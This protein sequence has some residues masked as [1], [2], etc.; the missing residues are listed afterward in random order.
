MTSAIRPPLFRFSL[1]KA[2]SRLAAGVLLA[3]FFICGLV[4]FVIHRSEIQ[5]RQQASVTVENLSQVIEQYLSGLVDKTD[6]ALLS[7]ADEFARQFKA[8]GIDRASLDKFVQQRHF[9][10]P[11]LGGLRIADRQ[12]L[13]AIGTG[14]LS[15][16]PISIADRPYFTRLR[17]NADAGLVIFG[18]VISR[19]TGKWVLILA[20]RL[21]DA[22][23]GFAG[24]VY[25]IV[26]VASV[27]QALASLDLGEL[28]SITLYKYDPSHD[29]AGTI[30]ARH[31]K[32]AGPDDSVGSTAM[33]A[34]FRSLLLSG[35]ASA[36]YHARSGLDHVL[37]TF[38]YR[39]VPGHPLIV[40]V[41]MAD[42]DFLSGWRHEAIILIGLLISF[43]LLTVT[44]A[45]ALDRW[46]RRR[47]AE[48]ALAAGVFH[49]TQEGIMITDAK[50]RIVSANPAFSQIT[51]YSAEEAVGNDPRLF[52]SKRHDR[53][54]F[55]DMW[56]QLLDFGRWQG[57]IWNRRKNGEIYLSMLN[58]TAL[59]SESGEVQKFVAVFSDVTEL[60]HKDDQLKRMAYQDSL[61]GLPN[62]LLLADRLSQ[63]IELAKRSGT[64]VALLFIDLDNFKVVNDSLGHNVGDTLLGLVAERLQSSLRRS[65]TIARTGG[66][67]FVV[68]C[69]DVNDAGE[70]AEVAEKLIHR[71]AEPFWLDHTPMRIGASIGVALFPGDGE[72][73]TTLMRAADTAM[74]RAKAEGRN[75]FRFF[76]ASMMSAAV[77]RLQMESALRRA[78]SDGEFELYYQPKIDL[79]TGRALGSEA[80]IRWNRKDCGLVTPMAFIPVAEEIGLIC[81]IGD[82]VLM[83]A[84]RQLLE[85]KRL[86]LPP[87]SVAV[88]VSARQFSQKTFVDRIEALLAEHGLDPS[89]L[90][91]ELTEST[92]MAQP[93]RAVDQL[94]RLRAIGVNVAVD[95]FGTGYSSLSYLK[96]LP[97]KTIKIDRS[98]V[99]GVD[100]D[101]DN[102]AIVRAI[103]GLAESLGMSVVA[104]GVETEGEE[105]HLKAAG[106]GIAQG[107]RYAKPLPAGN[108]ALWLGGG[109]AVAQ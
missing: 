65:D 21:D 81:E 33:S 46:W 51:G 56:R 90:E 95:D 42:E 4:G 48:T 107:Y 11:N 74:Y 104:E 108:F 76:D 12:G 30:V 100:N 9:Q 24:I 1:A 2:T 88:N 50:G 34:E 59:R 69:P 20:R 5:Y 45:W 8:D 77:E 64:K 52:A 92:V 3:N 63:S 67:E 80:L 96:R 58:I 38:Y 14:D 105:A 32:G 102:R 39:W 62:R 83:E 78:L 15:N 53:A 66:D 71:L 49:T 75:N 106:C 10:P 44:S 54:F 93:D 17:D 35:Q 43:A 27:S 103:L 18:P 40:V 47:E 99:H 91:I 22:Q 16:F 31:A 101:V 109:E 82:W 23:G 60:R 29:G 25:S 19:V 85:W 72:D 26:D 86:G 36:S 7:V 98:F 73:L 94:L 70:V 97:L 13:V 68:I 28:G 6:F 41:G 55:T 84:C 87:L 79:R 57:E 89:L 37:R 61:T